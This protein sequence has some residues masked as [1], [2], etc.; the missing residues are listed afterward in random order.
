MS[1]NLSPLSLEL[2][3]YLDLYLIF[4]HLTHLFCILFS[5]LSRLLILDYAKQVYFIF[6]EN[7]LK[8]LHN[9]VLVILDNVIMHA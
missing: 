6:N 2:I 8:L 7:L 5:L 1:D 3:I 4:F 9:F